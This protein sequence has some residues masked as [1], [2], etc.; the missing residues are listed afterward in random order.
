MELKIR[1]FKKLYLPSH[2][3]GKSEKRSGKGRKK[4]RKKSESKKTKR[5]TN[6]YFMGI[7]MAATF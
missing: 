4:K 3:L 1:H 7:T 5:E 2:P 6:R